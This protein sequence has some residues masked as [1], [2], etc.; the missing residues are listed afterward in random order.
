MPRVVALV[1]AYVFTA[2]AL[3]GVVVPGLPT[4]P[5]LLLAAW[6]SAK[7]SERLHRWLYQHPQFG[8]LLIDWE[9]EGAVS[10][11]SKYL[12]LVT[13]CASWL[14]LYFYT[15]NRWL[16]AFVSVTFVCVITFL[17]TRPEPTRRD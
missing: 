14:F 2:L 10:R 12:A 6:F 17:F 7:G 1:L 5:F 16:L 13:L 4:V 8:Q 3:I 9:Q 15:D 11:G